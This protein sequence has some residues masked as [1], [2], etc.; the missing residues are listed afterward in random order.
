M[1]DGLDLAEEGPTL[2]LGPDRR[3]CR[4]TGITA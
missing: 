2:F 1:K 3:T 4:R